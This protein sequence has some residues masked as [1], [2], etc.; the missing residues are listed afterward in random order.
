[1]VPSLVPRGDV[2]GPVRVVDLHQSVNVVA[3]LNGYLA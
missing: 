1:M 2:A 3:L